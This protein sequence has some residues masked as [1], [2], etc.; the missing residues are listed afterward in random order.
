MHLKKAEIITLGSSLGVDYS[1]T[2]SCY[3]LDEQGAACGQCASCVLRS[4]GFATAN[5]TD[6]TK[7]S[8]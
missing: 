6:P 2:T 4:N 7:Y 3:Q 8:R 5:M 1:I